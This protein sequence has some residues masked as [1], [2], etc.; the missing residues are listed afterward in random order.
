MTVSEGY[1]QGIGDPDDEDEF[2]D[3]VEF[4]DED[5]DAAIAAAA[6]EDK[7]FVEATLAGMA[8]RL[9]D[10]EATLA[11]KE[12]WLFDVD[13]GDVKV[14]CDVDGQLR[15]FGLARD[16]MTS[17]TAQELQERLNAAFEALRHRVQ[18]VH[19]ESYGDGH[20]E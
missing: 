20:V 15:E 4:R 1:A 9:A 13:L 5:L 19:E 12:S 14:V 18:E 16:V 10:W 11:Q 2:G 3:A 7:A 6:A 17:Y 8:E